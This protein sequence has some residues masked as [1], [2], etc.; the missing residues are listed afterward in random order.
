M[1][2]KHLTA[3]EGANRR[4]VALP[5]A[6]V[7][8]TLAALVAPA[9]AAAA[10]LRHRHHAVRA[11]HT[12]SFYATVVTANQAGL[13]VVSATGQTL[14]FSSDQIRDERTAG[15][16]PARRHH[17]HGRPAELR[18]LA[19]AARHPQ[20]PGHSADPRP[21]PPNRPP[22]TDILDL[23]PGA[24]VLIIER[25]SSHGGTAVTVA[26]PPSNITVQETAS[27]VVTKVEG[28]AFD[29][30]ASDG[31]P[32]R[33]VMAHHKLARLDLAISDRVEVT[34]HQNAGVLIADQ[35]QVTAPST[36]RHVHHT[37]GKERA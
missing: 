34:Y 10:A 13:V 30:T 9:S 36:V 3:H 19:H 4:R 31:T 15:A 27:G 20:R 7:L 21:Q 33:L 35:V 17:G 11:A 6:L 16:R 1:D 26:L 29:M 37:A 32:L 24:T 28:R 25:L 14:H 23:Q 5:G 22:V 8:L 2:G 12:I 18:D